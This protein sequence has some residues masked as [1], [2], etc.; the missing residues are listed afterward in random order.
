M[1]IWSKMEDPNMS[2]SSESDVDYY[3]NGNITDKGIEILAPSIFGNTSLK[4]CDLSNNLGINI[5]SAGLL[6]EAVMKSCLTELK[7]EHTSITKSDIDDINELLL[8]PFEQREIPISSSSK[9]AAKS[10]SWNTF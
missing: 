8:V 2:E 5:L 7:L 1:L 9:S 4:A 10:L 3:R 6:K